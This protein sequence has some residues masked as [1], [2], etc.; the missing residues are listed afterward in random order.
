MLN[1]RTYCQ[2]LPQPNNCYLSK[3]QDLVI[4]G[5]V[6]RPEEEEEKGPGFQP[7]MESVMFSVNIGVMSVQK[8]VEVVEFHCN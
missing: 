5:L 6:L 3:L 2:C 1:D 8:Y 4:F 7:F